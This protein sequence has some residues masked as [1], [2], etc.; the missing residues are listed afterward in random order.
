MIDHL[1][2]QERMSKAIRTLSSLWKPVTEDDIRVYFILLILKGIMNKPS[3]VMCSSKD[4]IFLTLIFSRIMPS[5]KF[6]RIRKF[7]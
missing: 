5:D 3:Y 7:H 2:P 6:E 4:H 1:K